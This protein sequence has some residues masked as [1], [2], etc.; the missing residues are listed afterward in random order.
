MGIREKHGAGRE[1]KDPE[2]DDAMDTKGIHPIGVYIEKLEMNISERVA[3]RP[4]NMHGG[5]EDSGDK[6][7]GVLVVSRRSN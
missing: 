3:S 5:R 1:W 2:V 7:Y 4:C 6:L